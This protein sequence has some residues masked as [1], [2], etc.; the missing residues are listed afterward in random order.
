MNSLATGLQSPAPSARPRR[1][2][3]R[4]RLIDRHVATSVS[5]R[6]S[7]RCKSGD[8][9]QDTAGT[10][11]GNAQPSTRA[12]IATVAGTRV[13]HQ[14]EVASM[15]ITAPK[16]VRLVRALGTHSAVARLTMIRSTIDGVEKRLAGGET[17][18][19]SLRPS[20]GAARP[21]P[22]APNQRRCD[23]WR[24]TVR[25]SLSSAAST[26]HVVCRRRRC[27]RLP[28][29]P[30]AACTAS[31]APN[32]WPSAQTACPSGGCCAIIASRVV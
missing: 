17:Q 27:R 26:L 14:A 20:A 22:E 2:H 10:I 29:L 12:V 13:E 9:A 31:C 11:G 21:P 24:K 3:D 15:I 32:T 7:A 6:W 5:T 28:H 19:R 25:I 1:R 30:C 23:R 16:C 8:A 18:E 4:D